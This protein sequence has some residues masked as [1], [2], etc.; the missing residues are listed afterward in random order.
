MSHLALTGHFTIK[1]IFSA[2][3]GA[4]RGPYGF[5]FKHVSFLHNGVEAVPDIPIKVGKVRILLHHHVGQN[6]ILMQKLLKVQLLYIG[7][8]L[9]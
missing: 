1:V 3:L 8:L 7:L 5:H 6:N 9:I 4:V 2:T